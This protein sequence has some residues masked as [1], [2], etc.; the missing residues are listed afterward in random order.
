MGLPGG[1][2]LA[3]VSTAMH[4]GQVIRVTGMEVLDLRRRPDGK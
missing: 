4:A 2:G 1:S 3:L